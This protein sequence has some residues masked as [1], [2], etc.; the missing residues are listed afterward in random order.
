[1]TTLIS[2][3]LRSRI[4][5]AGVVAAAVI[6]AVTLLT[7]PPV[8]QASDVANG[9]LVATPPVATV[10]PAVVSTLGVFRRAA[11]SED[12]PSASIIKAAGLVPTHFGANPALSRLA[13]ITAQGAS[14]YLTPDVGGACLFESTNSNALCATVAQIQ[15]GQASAADICSPSLPTG[16]VEIAGIVPD[17]VTN[18]TVTLSNGTSEPLPIENNAY[19]IRAQ[20]SSPLPTKVEWTS[21]SGEQADA[22]ALPPDAATTTCAATRAQAAA[23]S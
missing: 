11:T 5:I 19:V 23:K 14:V 9:G 18:A 8:T 2:G 7:R 13:F 22:A 15:E 3:R 4:V 12:I 20:Q 17:A 21:A 1:M 10:D 16:E 6:V